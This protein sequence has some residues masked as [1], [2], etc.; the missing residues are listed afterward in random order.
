M[1]KALSL[2]TSIIFI[3]T[4]F[5]ACNNENSNK[6]STAISITDD[7]ERT[8]N[9]SSANKVVAAS[10][11]LAEI[12]LLAGGSLLG[13]TDDAFDG[14]FRISQDTKNIGK[15]HQINLETILEINPDLVIL[16]AELSSQTKMKSALESADINALYLSIES[17]D[18]YLS[19]LKKLTEITQREDLY[20]KNGTDLQETIA[21]IISEV[22]KNQSPE[23][24]LLRANSTKLE[25]RNSE[26]LA[27]IILKDMGCKNIADS[28]NN[29]LENLSIE[30]IIKSNPD[31]I[32]AILQGED[33][34]KA[35]NVLK[36]TLQES[37]I[38]NNLDA[39]KNNKFIILPKELF[40]QKPNARWHESYKMI[41]EILYG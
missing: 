37:T 1:K 41:W 9:I 27:G 38:W 5:A 12:W 31:Y 22:P 6:E 18:D 24:L 28:D 13:A 32:F 20:K 40:H 14:R 15:L 30:N 35:R 3:L 4:T 26:T 11:S 10:G 19:A 2:I 25:A 17:F 29:I 36:T 8:I 34:Q 7:L 21:Q 23:I 39:V 33:E 16:S